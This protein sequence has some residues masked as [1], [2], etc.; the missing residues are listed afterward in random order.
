MLRWVSPFKAPCNQ[1]RIRTPRG[2]RGAPRDEL[3]PHK[4]NHGWR[5]RPGPAG[6][7]R[8]RRTNQGPSGRVRA[9]RDARGPFGMD[10]VAVQTGRGIPAMAIG[11]HQR[12]INGGQHIPPPPLAK[13]GRL[14]GPQA[15]AALMRLAAGFGT[16]RDGSGLVGQSRA[17]QPAGLTSDQGPTGWIRALHDESGPPRDVSGLRIMNQ[18]PA[19]QTGALRTDQGPAGRIRAMG[20]IRTPWERIRAPGPQNESWSRWTNPAW[21]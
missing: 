10:A 9:L 5:N 6:R 12:E 1:S 16:T 11:H 2:W 14:L 21:S 15:E 13:V 4:M 17:P 8:V 7:T 18:G 19:G 20:R 3:G